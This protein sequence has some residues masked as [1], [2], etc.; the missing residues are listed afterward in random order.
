MIAAKK[1]KTFCTTGI[2][3]HGEMGEGGIGRIS[4][5]IIVQEGLQYDGNYNKSVA[6]PVCNLEI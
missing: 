1:K 6:S 2:H 3:I 4:T 5:K